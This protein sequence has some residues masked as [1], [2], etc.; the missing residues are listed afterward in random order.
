MIHTRGFRK[1]ITRKCITRDLRASQVSPVWFMGIALGSLGAT[2]LR[3]VPQRLDTESETLR[4][5]ETLALGWWGGAYQQ[6][7]QL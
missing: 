7:F 4:H 2:L 5:I 6:P 3:H 1:G